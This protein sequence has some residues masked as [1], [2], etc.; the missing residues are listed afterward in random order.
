MRHVLERWIHSVWYESASSGWPLIPLS[1]LYQSVISI[2]K[3]AYSRRLR[4]SFKANAKVIVVGNIT[5]GGVGK[6][7]LVVWLCET[8]QNKG[9]KV[10]VITRGYGGSLDE[11][12]HVTERHLPSEVGDEALM[13][14]QRLN[15]PVVSGRNRAASARLLQSMGVDMIVA[16]DGLQH[17]ALHRD[18]EICV[19]DGQRLFGNGRLLPAG[20]LRERVSRLQN[21]DVVVRHVATLESEGSMTLGNPTVWQLV[22]DATQALSAFSGQAVHAVAGLGN[23]AR[24]FASL[25]EAGLK[26][27]RH[28]FPDHHAY[29]PEDVE[30]GDQ[31][32]VLMTDKDAVKCKAFARD[33]FFAVRVDAQ[34]SSDV[35]AAIIAKV[36]ALEVQ[37]SS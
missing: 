26:I 30:F 15:L 6:T 22:T 35:E 11:S 4:S 9:Y 27:I 21:V 33:C 7:P 8:L 24:F 3:F 23:P 10:G 36:N 19:V 32:P 31:L 13:L 18:I 16:D 1:W 14:A 2:R 34:L 20:P 5:A 12:T 37:R 28:S 29:R 17:Y 25:E